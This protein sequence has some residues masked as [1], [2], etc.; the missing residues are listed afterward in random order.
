MS[1]KRMSKDIKV[2]KFVYK[3]KGVLNRVLNLSF[4]SFV[5]HGN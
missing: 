3:R 1:Y 2:N 5:C 4:N